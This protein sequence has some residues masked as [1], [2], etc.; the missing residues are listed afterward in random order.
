M[1]ILSIRSFFRWQ[2]G[3]GFESYLFAGL[4]WNILIQKNWRKNIRSLFHITVLRLLRPHCFEVQ[5][6]TFISTFNLFWAERCLWFLELRKFM[7]SVSVNW[8]HFLVH[9]YRYQILTLEADTDTDTDTGVLI[10]ADTD[11]DTPQK[12]RYYRY[13]YRYR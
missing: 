8:A 10:A 1:H 4:F 3:C 6:H 13:R 2:Q 5:C 7:V 12:G 9:R 11:T